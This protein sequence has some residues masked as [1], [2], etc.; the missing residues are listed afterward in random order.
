MMNFFEMQ[1]F[2]FQPGCEPREESPMAKTP[3][4][5][6]YATPF[7]WLIEWGQRWSLD[8]YYVQCK[9]CHY[10]QDVRGAEQPFAHGP[11]CYNASQFGDYPFHDL[12]KHLSLLKQKVP[13]VE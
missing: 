4:A 12:A 9:V 6:G 5:V 13:P 10:L 1:E 2:S 8:G 11:E 3:A 7:G